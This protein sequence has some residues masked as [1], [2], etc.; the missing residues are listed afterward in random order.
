MA[1]KTSDAQRAARRRQVLD[2]AFI[3]F[4]RDGFHRTSMDDI[5]R[6][7][8]MS[9]GA[10]YGYFSGKRELITA[11][12]EERHRQE[13]EI[14]ERALACPDPMAALEQLL[15]DYRLWLA[16]PGE[17]M[18]RRVG[19]E[20]WA[21]A[22]RGTSLDREIVE[23]V[24]AARSAVATLLGRI[25]DEGVLSPRTDI[26]TASRALVALFQG[27]ALQLSWNEE[28]DLDEY[29]KVVESFVRTVIFQEGEEG[30]AA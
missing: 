22:S 21:E 11:I 5:V 17:R 9:P 8:G 20:I 10:I 28:A 26:D 7:S 15:R 6:Q 2:A 12:A 25:A 13:R 18:R 16:D 14:N 27:L 24:D 3:C 23:G 29:L 4:A 1:P 19:V 30:P